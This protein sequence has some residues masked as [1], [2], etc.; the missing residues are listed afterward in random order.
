MD[1]SNFKL[2]PPTYKINNIH[3]TINVINLGLN[4]GSYPIAGLEGLSFGG[5]GAPFDLLGTYGTEGT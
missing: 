3:V 5:L 2:E 4:A 1:F